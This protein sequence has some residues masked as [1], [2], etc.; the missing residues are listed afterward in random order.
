MKLD[1]SN[2]SIG[3][4]RTLIH[5]LNL[6]MDLGDRLIVY[7]SN[8]TG[9]STLL[10]TINKIR[11]NLPPEQILFLHQQSSFH[12]Q[13]PDDVDS[14]LLNILFYKKPFQKPSQK[15]FNAI[16]EVKNKLH[17]KNMPLKNLSGGQRQKLKIAR[18]L[19]T[20][21]KALLLDEPFNAIDQ[22]STHEIIDWL[23]TS[24]PEMIQIIVLHDFDQIEK[25]KSK[26][27]WIQESGW[28]ILEFNDWFQKV[29]K[30]F[31]TW[32]HSVQGAK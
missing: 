5:N 11:W 4:D 21:T 25:L 8:G 27:L 3:Y 20:N 23:N 12:S 32:I 6:Q 24:R 31:H 13:T 2:L 22:T 15:D 17:L 9:K 28:E 1:I 14:Y 30:R 29:D 10:Q 26:V 16:T 7:G 18:A 19:L